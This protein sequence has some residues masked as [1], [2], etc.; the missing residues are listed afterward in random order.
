MKKLSILLLLIL[1]LV[2]CTNDGIF[3][4]I[5]ESEMYDPTKINGA[6]GVDGTKLY[7]HT[8]TGI[9][10]F[11]TDDNS[12]TTLKS[13]AD[14]N[15][16]KLYTLAS[17]KDKITLVTKDNKQIVYTI[18]TESW[19]DPADNTIVFT[20]DKT[21]ISKDTNGYTFTGAITGTNVNL[22]TD[23]DFV[24]FVDGVIVSQKGDDNAA[25][26][27]YHIGSVFSNTTYSDNK[28]TLQ[29]FDGTYLYFTYSD[30]SKTKLDVVNKNGTKLLT[31][32]SPSLGAEYIT[33]SKGSDNYV[34]SANNSVVYKLD[35]AN[36]ELDKIEL[37]D[38]AVRFYDIINV[39][40][41]L[42]ALTYDQGLL[43]LDL[44]KNS[45]EDN[46]TTHFFD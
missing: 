3:T 38:H 23:Y 22:S 19:T 31:S 12:Y 39:N 32:E 7:Y 34:T 40:N 42:I 4:S 45:S 25:T 35:T 15:S 14:I 20:D 37:A 44:S 30:D 33:F 1:T 9:H 24:R 26:F 10:C 36:K 17:T 16:A 8:S 2:S 29:A 27:E 11:D 46:F 41:T 5:L 6:I 21:V 18:A 13:N 28:Y 43:Q